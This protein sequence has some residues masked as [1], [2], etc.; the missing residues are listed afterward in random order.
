MEIL[1]SGPLESSVTRNNQEWLIMWLIDKLYDGI[2]NTVNEKGWQYP[3]FCGGIR[4]RE[5]T[6]TARARIGYHSIASWPLSVAA[7]S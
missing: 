4:K 6:T 5:K 3:Q 7:S 2:P 1:R